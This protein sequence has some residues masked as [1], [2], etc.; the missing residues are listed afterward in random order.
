MNDEKSL[1]IKVN[2]VSNTAI[3][4]LIMLANARYEKAMAI[5][6][7]MGVEKETIFHGVDPSDMVN[8]PS[9]IVRELRYV[10]LNRTIEETGRW[11]S[12]LRPE[13]ASAGSRIWICTRTIRVL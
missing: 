8:R 4:T 7:Q 6:E 1:G 10:A 3:T 5:L 2:P 12:S 13:K 9:D 11:S